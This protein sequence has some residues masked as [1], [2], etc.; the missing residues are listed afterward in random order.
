M[1][2]LGS[3]LP[4]RSKFL[5]SLAA[6]DNLV[7]QGT[8]FIDLS[9]IASIPANFIRESKYS[10]IAV[11]VVV[12][13]FEA[14]ASFGSQTF[15][16][17]LPIILPSG[18]GEVINFAMTDANFLI[19]L[20]VKS[21]NPV[22]ILQI[23]SSDETG[24]FLS[25]DHGGTFEANLPLSVG[26]AGVNIDVDFMINDPNVFQ[27][28]PVVDY[29]INL[30]EVSDAL[31]DL[32]DQLK[33][34]IV[35][36]VKEPFGDKPVTFNI[37][38]IT[39]PLIERVESALAQFVNGM[40]VAYSSVD[41]GQT[42]NSSDIPSGIPSESP[43]TFPTNVLSSFPSHAPSLLDH[44]TAPSEIPSTLPSNVPSGSRTTSPSSQPTLVQSSMPSISTTPSIQASSSSSYCGCSSCDAAVWDSPALHGMAIPQ[45]IAGNSQGSIGTLTVTGA[46]AG[47]FFILFFTRK[48]EITQ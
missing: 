40:N 14:T 32:F 16:L 19:D 2:I 39:D 38:R 10:D 42:T 43:S 3:V 1:S 45:E 7:L 31:M 9:I 37:D 17:D 41:C 35:S 22:D 25:L 4:I 30:C 26:V 24:T 13:Q 28:D 36:A 47:E 48:Y 33:E 23:F 34:K 27:P 46:G 11:S 44:S 12:N 18:D 5:D 21:T 20:Y 6:L 15:S 8:L 29:A